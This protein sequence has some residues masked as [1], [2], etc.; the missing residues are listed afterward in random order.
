MKSR[1]LTLSLIVAAFF[2]GLAWN[3]SAAISAP[4]GYVPFEYPSGTYQPTDIFYN[5]GSGVK[6]VNFFGTLYSFRDEAGYFLGTGSGQEINAENNLLT[7]G[8]FQNNGNSTQVVLRDTDHT[9]KLKA[10]VILPEL[11][12]CAKLATDGNGKVFCSP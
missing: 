5:G 1:L 11:P 3:S 8:D 2:C 9:I 10:D 7:L 4:M 6:A 12:N